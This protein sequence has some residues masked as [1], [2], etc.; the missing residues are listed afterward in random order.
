MRFAPIKAINGEKSHHKRD[1][2]APLPEKKYDL[3][4]KAVWTKRFIRNIAVIKGAAHGAIPTTPA[5]ARRAIGQ[6]YEEFLTN[7]YMPEM[8]LRYRNKHER[9][10]YPDEPGREPG[11]GLVE[12]FR[13][14]I[15][16]FLKH[17]PLQ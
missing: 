13:E 1:Y 6:N 14:F 10:V 9:K 8:L 4:N 2:I 12:E 15:L 17:Y 5:L 3:I 16:P 7:L 11:T